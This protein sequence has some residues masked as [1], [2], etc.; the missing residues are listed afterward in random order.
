MVADM[1]SACV[2]GV[3]LGGTKVLAGTLDADMQVH[4]RAQRAVVG[5]EQQA[6]L[7]EVIAA[8]DEVRAATELPV[9]AVGFG[10]PCLIDQRRGM[11]VM[12]VNLPITDMP[13]RDVMTERLGLPVFIDNDANV[14]ALA[15]HRYGA[16]KGARNSVMLTVGTG[17]GGG[18]ILDDAIYRGSIGSGAELGHMVIEI[19]GPPCQGACPNHGCL[20]AVASGTAL[21][22]EARAAAEAS[23]DSELGKLAASGREVTGAIVTELAHDGD[24]ASRQV[25]ALIGQR[26]GVGIANYVNIFNPEVVV[27]G[28][29][30]IAAGE[31]LL[32]P[33]RAEVAERALH[34]SKDLVEIV[35]AHFANEAGML[36]A[37]ALAFDGIRGRQ[38][39][40][41]EA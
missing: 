8:V 38:S 9:E 7:D 14:A 19:D 10:I 20:E 37:A 18:L 24:A 27:V 13:F 26:L 5:L 36:G 11:A 40:A 28:G 23:P 17:V 22:R 35:P 21:V 29:G 30:V 31:L 32:E 4:H 1:S 6:L 34:P 12:A 25:I 33:A 41:A 2:V 39:E 3:D 15:E 16:A